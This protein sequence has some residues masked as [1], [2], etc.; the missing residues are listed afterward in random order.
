M[1]I[2]IRPILVKNGGVGGFQGYKGYGM[3]RMTVLNDTGGIIKAGLTPWD[4]RSYPDP[5][6]GAHLGFIGLEIPVVRDNPDV[7][8]DATGSYP[9]KY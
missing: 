6:K 1:Q 7:G 2:I 5:T 4:F 9:G 8:D 3:A